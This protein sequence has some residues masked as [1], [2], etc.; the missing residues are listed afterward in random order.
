M[1]S[2]KLLVLYFTL[3]GEWTIESLQ[4]NFPENFYIAIREHQRVDPELFIK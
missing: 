1:F 2:A 4:V 3:K